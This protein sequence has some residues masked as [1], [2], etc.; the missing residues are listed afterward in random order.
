LRLEEAH[1]KKTLPSRIL[2][3]QFMLVKSLI[4]EKYCH[5]TQPEVFNFS[6]SIFYSFVMDEAIIRAELKNVVVTLSVVN[7][8]NS[9]IA[10]N[11]AFDDSQK[12]VIM[13]NLQ[14]APVQKERRTEHRKNWLL[15]MYKY[16]I[17]IFKLHSHKIFISIDLQ[18]Q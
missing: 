17:S 9:R 5:K 2:F 12:T 10:T 16:H 13:S 3:V 14:S 15:K 4:M 11:N 6:F 7:L 8:Q 18:K 1:G